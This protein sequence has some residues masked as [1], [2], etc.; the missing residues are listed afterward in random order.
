MRTPSSRAYSASDFVA[1]N[2]KPNMVTS[3]PSLLLRRATSQAVPPAP[4]TTN[5]PPTSTLS[6]RFTRLKNSIPLSTFGASSPAR[7]NRISFLRANAGEHGC[8]FTAQLLQGNVFAHR[9]IAPQ[10]DPEIENAADLHGK[11]FTRQAEFRNAVTQ[12]ASRLAER[13]EN[14]DRVSA[15]D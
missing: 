9:A 6:P 15:T 2:S 1:V 4:T 13:F 8:I 12:H 3:A 14:G 11:N 7:F 10:L 5:R